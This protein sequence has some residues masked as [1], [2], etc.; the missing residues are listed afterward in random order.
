MVGRGAADG[1]KGGGKGGGGEVVI[2]T[3]PFVR[4]LLPRILDSD[5]N[6]LI[7]RDGP[8]LLSPNLQ[9]ARICISVSLPSR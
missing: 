9:F 2:R 8:I 4:Q 6:N 5:Q 7:F 3:R 1:M